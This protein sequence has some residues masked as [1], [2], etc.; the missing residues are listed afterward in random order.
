MRRFIVVIWDCCLGDGGSSHS[1]CFH[2]NVSSIALFLNLFGVRSLLR[3]CS[4]LSEPVLVLLF[5]DLIE[6]LLIPDLFTVHALL[7]RNVLVTG[8]ECLLLLSEFS[9]DFLE[10]EL[11]GIVLS[12]S[13][14]LS[15]YLR[16]LRLPSLINHEIGRERV[17]LQLSNQ[18]NLPHDKAIFNDKLASLLLSNGGVF[19]LH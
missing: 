13:L 15:C 4:T 6:E 19:G 11:G 3:S 5:V 9:H 1:L 14:L 7:L 12:N 8:L 2:L 10:L 17:K 18:W 16:Q